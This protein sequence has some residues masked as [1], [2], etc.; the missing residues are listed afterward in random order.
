[1]Q[2]RF[3]GR[4]QVNEPPWPTAV[5]T[6]RPGN[7]SCCLPYSFCGLNSAQRAPMY[8]QSKALWSCC[9]AAHT[10]IFVSKLPC[11]SRI[12][13]C[14]ILCRILQCFQVV[15][16]LRPSQQKDKKMC[17]MYAYVPGGCLHTANVS[18]LETQHVH[19]CSIP[20][21][22]CGTPARQDEDTFSARQRFRRGSQKLSC[23]ANTI[24]V[25]YS[26]TQFATTACCVYGRR[27]AGST[28]SVRSHPTQACI[29]STS[30]G[31]RLHLYSVS[32]IHQVCPLHLY[33]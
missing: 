3:A 20:P 6:Y 2:G 8:T 26:R 17:N 10:Y 23:L 15:V 28:E 5:R 13:S 22:G 12:P 19:I 32:P 18:K 31:G 27:K 1:M 11:I 9:A 29:D 33:P 24:A 16:L 14:S 4:L 21:K 30:R 25:R 7:I